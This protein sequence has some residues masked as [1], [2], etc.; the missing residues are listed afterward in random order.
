MTSPARIATSPSAAEPPGSS[1]SRRARTSAGLLV[2]AAIVFALGVA[3]ARMR[4]DAADT[5]ATV[6]PSLPVQ[7][8]GGLPELPSGPVEH[9]E[10]AYFHRTHRCSACVNAER[11]TRATLEESFSERLAAG[12]IALS[13]EDA[14]A[15]EDPGLVRRYDAWGS[16]LYLGITKGGM[17]YVYRLDD[18]WFYV[19]QDHQFKSYLANQIRKAL[20]DS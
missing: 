15:P 1:T 16:A 3:M 18:V 4:A 14:E 5:V 8:V 6:V 19:N 20:G 10:V 9:L 11:L 12:Q 13:V 2:A 7:R 17:V